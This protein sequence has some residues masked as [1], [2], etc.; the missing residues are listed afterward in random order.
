MPIPKLFWHSAKGLPCC[1]PVRK[2][3]AR[4]SA[5][6]MPQVQAI[7]VEEPARTIC[8]P[9]LTSTQDGNFHNLQGRLSCTAPH[10][11]SAKRMVQTY[12]TKCRC[13][14][15]TGTLGLAKS[16]S[17]KLFYNIRWVLHLAPMLFPTS[18]HKKQ[19]GFV[20]EISVPS[21]VV[22]TG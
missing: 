3:T 14:T 12:L 20:S 13:R 18:R 15:V 5:A 9:Q 4:C 10:C 19:P 17:S 16:L 7:F 11:A 21:P 22:R 2:R 6:F 8:T 1:G